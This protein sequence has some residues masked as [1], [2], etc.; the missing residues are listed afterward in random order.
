MSKKVLITGSEG[1]IGSHLV[2]YLVTKG[3]SVKAF[4]YYN[5][6]NSIGW[7]N[8]LDKKILAEVE[9]YNGDIRNI[10][11]TDIAVK[12]CNSI[13]HLAS[14]IGIPYSY[15]TPQSYV[16]TNVKGTTNI[17]QSALKNNVNN[18]IHTSTSEVYG[19]SKKFPISENNPLIG[20]SP[21]AASKI[22]ADQISY[23]FF[24][25]YDLPVKIIRPFNTFGPRQSL[26][27]IIPSIISQTLFS[28]N[29]E[30][31]IGS[32]HPKRDF[33][34][35]KD[36]VRAFEMILKKS[37]AIG[38]VINIGSGHEISIKNLAKL[39]AKVSDKK[40]KFI[41]DKNR[42]RPSQSEV[43]RLLCDNRKAGMILNWEPKYKGLKGLEKG[44]HET[45]NWIKDNSN[46][47][48]FIQKYI[49]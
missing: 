37:K 31:K 42:L 20:Q 8:T 11:S 4:V 13:I 38:E 32:L 17:L 49:K 6:F 3:Y 2:D 29:N 41:S 26:R 16:D 28:K 30:I 19:N 36:T 48:Y 46:K 43:N 35:V 24:C 7:L 21:Y 45:I 34:Y 14:L 25:S 12:K 40:I 47:G 23:S 9:I 15:D 10:D 27:A 22:A 1:F 5:S 33:T 39:I 18:F 44:I